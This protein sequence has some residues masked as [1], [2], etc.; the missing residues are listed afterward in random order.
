[1]HKYYINTLYICICIYTDIK[2]FSKN[3]P[4]TYVEC[5]GFLEHNNSLVFHSQFWL[6]CY[7]NL[8]P[9]Q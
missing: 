2:K 1:M 5:N 9:D 8:A 3:I 7:Q 4:I 6:K